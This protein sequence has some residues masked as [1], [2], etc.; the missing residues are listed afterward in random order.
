M[1]KDIPESEVT[2][3]K[4]EKEGKKAVAKHNSSVRKNRKVSD[5]DGVGDFIDRIKGSPKQKRFA[6]SRSGKK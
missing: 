1:K 3:E 6:A 5:L 4:A 2:E